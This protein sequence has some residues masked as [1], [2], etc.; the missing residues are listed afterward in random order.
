MRADIICWDL[1]G[2][3]EPYFQH[4]G[5]AE[6]P[7]LGMGL[8]VP[9]AVNQLCMQELGTFFPAPFGRFDGLVFA[10][11]LEFREGLVDQGPFS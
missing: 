5:D 9:Q 1:A 11:F 2:R 10:L 6:I 8:G 4:L 3:L 7:S